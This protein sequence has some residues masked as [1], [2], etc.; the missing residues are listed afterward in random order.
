LNGKIQNI[1][2]TLD[3]AMTCKVEQ[4]R[5]K[6]IPIIETILFCGLQNISLR[7]RRDDSSIYSVDDDI[8][9]Q[10]GNFKALL[11]FRSNSKRLFQI[12]NKKYYLY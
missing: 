8:K 11:E 1:K 6:L 2:T 9:N 5:Q 3:T 7:G 12:C 4:N 10:K